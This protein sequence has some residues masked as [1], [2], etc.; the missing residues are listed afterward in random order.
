MDDHPQI[1]AF[2]EAAAAL[3][4]ERYWS[5]SSVAERKEFLFALG[6][7]MREVCYHLDKNGVLDPVS[8]RAFQQRSY[9]RI[10]GKLTASAG[11]ILMGSLQSHIDALDTEDE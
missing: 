5:Y 10:P 9:G 6:E 8:M 7:V 3:K 2:I 1:K 11:V 4:E